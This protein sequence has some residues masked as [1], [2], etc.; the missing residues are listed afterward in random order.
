MYVEQTSYLISAK[1]YSSFTFLFAVPVNNNT[2]E[3]SETAL[4]MSAASFSPQ[5][6][7][8]SETHPYDKVKS[9]HGYSKIKKK[10]IVLFLKQQHCSTLS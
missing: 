5:A 10:G 3:S 8:T 4:R 9:N 7:E 1:R 6:D 2:N